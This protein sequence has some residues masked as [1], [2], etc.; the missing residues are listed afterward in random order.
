MVAWN[1]ERYHEVSAPQQAWGRRM[2][3]RLP[4]EGHERVLDLG[5]GT[6]RITAEIAAR[7]PRGGVGGLDRSESMLQTASVW[8]REHSPRPPLVMADGAQLPFSRA[9]DAV[10]SGATFHWIA[11]HAALFRSIGT[12]LRP[13]AGW[14]RSAAAPA[15]LRN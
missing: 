11:D 2:L 3:E 5:C 8:L 4:L 7:V 10:F 9:F 15:T 1:A 6:G 12:A 13:G 14:S